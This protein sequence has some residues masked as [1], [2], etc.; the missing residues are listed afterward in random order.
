MLVDSPFF[1]APG[2]LPS[3]V[4]LPSISFLFPYSFFSSCL[5]SLSHCLY[6]FPF[7]FPHQAMFFSLLRFPRLRFSFMWSLVAG[8]KPSSGSIWPGKLLVSLPVSQRYVEFATPCSSL[9]CISFLFP[10]FFFL[11]YA[12]SSVL[13]SDIRSLPLSLLPVPLSSA[14]IFYFMCSP[15]RNFKPS[16]GSI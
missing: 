2:L 4:F 14:S 15:I 12:A 16:S 8:V 5:L 13:F 3:K 7:L 10:F 11:Y 1:C 9:F 6:C